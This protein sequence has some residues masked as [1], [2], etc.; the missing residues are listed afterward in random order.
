MPHHTGR[1][2]V[3]YESPQPHFGIHRMVFALFR[4][5][6]R[7]MMTAPLMRSKFNTLEFAMQHNLGLPVAA[8]FFNCQREGGTGGRRLRVDH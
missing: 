2:I 5:A 6:G 4:Q 1:E 7:Q 8:A 3:C